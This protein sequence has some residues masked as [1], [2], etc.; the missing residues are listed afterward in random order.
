MAYNAP[1]IFVDS[2]TPIFILGHLSSQIELF[3]I[4]H[5]VLRANSNYFAKYLLC[6]SLLCQTEFANLQIEFV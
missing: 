6:L 5:V 4:L 1:K 3:A 2:E